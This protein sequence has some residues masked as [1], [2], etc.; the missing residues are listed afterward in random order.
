MQVIILS[1]NNKLFKQWSISKFNFVL[2]LLLLQAMIIM[3]TLMATD[4]YD[5]TPSSVSIIANESESLEQTDPQVYTTN[6]FDEEVSRDFYAK[7]IGDLQA[8]TI[9][10]K[11]LSERLAEMVGFDIST[12][13]MESK[14]GMGGL[15][16]EGISLSVAEFEQEIEN[17]SSHI[18]I[19][20]NAFSALEQFVITKQTITDAIP[21]GRPIEKGWLTSPYGDRIDPFNG[22][23]T[24]HRGIDFA[25]KAGDSVIAVAD[26]IVT[27]VGK[28]SGYGAV[29]EIEHGNGYL[30]RYAH[31]KDVVVKVGERVDKG[32]QIALMGNTGRSTGPHVHFEVHRD[33]KHLN[34][35]SFLK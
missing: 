29:V 35:Y 19:Q 33:G 23:K 26:G 21:Q 13:A 25:G 15:E 20:E 18:R 9:R 32:Q 34:P 28:N 6:I 4:W 12:F 5:R 14:P 10:L 2:V 17:I 8:E 11:L 30:T 31:N 24:F 22:K 27:W 16:S 1:S 7:R 3:A